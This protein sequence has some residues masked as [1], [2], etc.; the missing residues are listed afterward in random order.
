MGRVITLSHDDVGQTIHVP[1][2]LALPGSQAILR[3]DG[4][5][6]G[7]EPLVPFGLLTLLATLEPIDD[8]L[9]LISDPLPDT[10]KL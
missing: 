5:R 4:N 8:D 1:E 9:G 3:R 7:V 10:V 6:L 2:D